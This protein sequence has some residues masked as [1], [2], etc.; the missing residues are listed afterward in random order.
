M[1]KKKYLLITGL[2]FILLMTFLVAGCGQS[3]STAPA[4]SGPKK[5]KIGYSGGAC[6]AFLFSAYE[7]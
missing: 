7:K 6:E 4:A 5:V 1:K 2:I 3:Q